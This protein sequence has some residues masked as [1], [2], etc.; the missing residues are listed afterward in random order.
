[1]FYNNFMIFV[2]GF[3]NAPNRGFVTTFS[4]FT[5]TSHTKKAQ[6]RQSRAA[7]FGLFYACAV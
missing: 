2:T 1:M 4:G 3:H 5:T 7:V 6:T